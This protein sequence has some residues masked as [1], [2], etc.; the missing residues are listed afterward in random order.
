MKA[1]DF[2]TDAHLVERIVIEAEGRAPRVFM[3]PAKAVV[4]HA[5]LT[6]LGVAAV[7]RVEWRD[8]HSFTVSSTGHV[9]DGSA[10]TTGATGSC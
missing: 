5:H 3:V 8:G 1:K 7:A 10:S 2:F 9:G 6:R 4:W